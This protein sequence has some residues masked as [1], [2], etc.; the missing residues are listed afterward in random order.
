MLCIYTHLYI[1]DTNICKY[2]IRSS[3]YNADDRSGVAV[4]LVVKTK[5]TPC[6]TTDTEAEEES[7]DEASNECYRDDPLVMR[8]S[9]TFTTVISA[10]K[11]S[12]FFRAPQ[13]CVILLSTSPTS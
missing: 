2:P 3:P 5:V 6:N 1:Q 10:T 11:R 13:T 4:E 12:F 8:V 9:K 7:L